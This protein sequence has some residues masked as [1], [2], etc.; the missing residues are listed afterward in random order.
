MLAGQAHGAT[1]QRL[2]LAALGDSTTVGIGDP[3]PGGGW[4][5]WARLLADA[6]GATYDVSFSNLSTSGAT[7][8]S[9][10]R[11]QL[12]AGVAHRPDLASLV[13]GLNDTLRPGWDPARVR[14]EVMGCAEA[15]T[16]AGATLMTARFH[17]HARVL[18][19]P[20]WVRRPLWARVEQVNLVVDEV[21]RTFG[22]LVVDLAACP[23]VATRPFWSADRV[24]PSE[25]G[26]RAVARRWA[27]QLMAAG[28][29]VVP[30]SAQC[31]R[32]PVPSWR[33]D[34]A[35]LRDGGALWC[36]KQARSL[37]PGAVRLAWDGLVAGQVRATP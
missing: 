24:H 1:M 6:L 22:G 16:D 34:L 10:L 2:R 17:D 7:A 19:L 14:Q 33:T 3:L 5:G 25:Y 9:V 18:G 31:D 30:P 36:G 32:R 23:E 20:G 11:D 12:A 27:G 21:H 29:D 26:H 35:W 4:R 13:V 37:G 28:L 8:G 15:L